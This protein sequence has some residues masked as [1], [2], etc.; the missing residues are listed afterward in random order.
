MSVSPE[1]KAD[2]SEHAT[3]R[4]EIAPQN[5]SRFVSKAL[6]SLDKAA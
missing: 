2:P 5:G 4:W 1:K 6:L 3:R